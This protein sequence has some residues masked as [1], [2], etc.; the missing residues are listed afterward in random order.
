MLLDFLPARADT[1]TYNLNFNIIDLVAPFP[2]TT[3]I[4]VSGTVET[5]CNQC[6]LIASNIIDYQFF[7]NGPD[8]K[9]E[10]AS[11]NVPIFGAPFLSIEPFNPFA[12][13]PIFAVGSY[14]IFDPVASNTSYGAGFMQFGNSNGLAAFVLNFSAA[15]NEI[16]LQ[17]QPD[18]GISFVNVDGVINLSPPNY[19]Q[20]G[21]LECVGVDC[22]KGNPPAPRIYFYNS[23]PSLSPPQFNQVLIN[24]LFTGESDPYVTPIPAALPLLAAGLGALGFFGWRRKRKTIAA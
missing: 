21:S 15:Y 19:L 9:G 22:I 2:P 24:G 13:M 14:L 4:N 18:L 5:T 12:V 20:L 7:F 6:S 16:S 1:Y 3:F 10:I 17:D 23:Q 11:T 8:V